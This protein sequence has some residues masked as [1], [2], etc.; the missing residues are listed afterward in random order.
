MSLRGFL[1][2]LFAVSLAIMLGLYW[3]QSAFERV[4]REGYDAKGKIVSAQITGNRFPFVFDGS[5]PRYVDEKLSIE[6]QWIG[7]DGV[8]RT[9]RGVAVS[10]AFAARITN[11]A[12]VKLIEIPIRAIDDDWT[13]PVIVEDA[14]DRLRNLRFFSDFAFN[15]VAVLGLALAIVIAWQKLSQRKSGIK[16]NRTRQSRPFPYRL[17]VLMAITLPFG[18]F[19]VVYSYYSQKDVEQMLHDGDESLAEITRAYGEV[20][21]PGEQPRYLI[22]FAWLGKDGQKR[23][24]GPTHISE[25]FYNQ[26]APHNILSAKQ[27]KIRY[28]DA[29]PNVRPLIVDD[30]AERQ[31]QD[32]AGI[33]GGAVS[34]GLGLILGGILVYRIRA[35]I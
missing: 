24:F 7:R 13:L 15:A 5:W 32:S 11:G 1:A 3:N 27:T 18:A 2:V 21:K 17:A 16:A 9:R 33:K 29:N 28:L 4:L 6:L 19:T 12:Q 30:A 8:E 20:R 34:L 10:P 22:N 26:I 14:D 23:V 35:R 31:F 25:T